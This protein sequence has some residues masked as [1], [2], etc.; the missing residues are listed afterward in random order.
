V[1]DIAFSV[2]RPTRKRRPFYFETHARARL[3]FVAV[4]RFRCGADFGLGFFGVYGA[5]GTC[6]PFRK[7]KIESPLYKT[8]PP[9]FFETRAGYLFVVRQISKV[10]LFT[11]RTAAVSSVEYHAPRTGIIG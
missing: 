11:F 5:A 8:L 2:F 7:S 3:R 4:M 6:G 10:S 9:G 1:D